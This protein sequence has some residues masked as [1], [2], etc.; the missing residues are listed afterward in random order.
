MELVTKAD[1]LERLRLFSDCPDDDNII[2]KQKIENALMQCPEILYAINERSLEG[3]LFNKDGTI[4]YDGEWDRYFTT[5]YNEGNFRPYLFVPS[6]QDEVKNYVCYQSHFEETP[7]YNGVEKYCLITFTIFV[8]SDHRIDEDTGIPRH[9][10]IGAILKDQ[11]NW[12][13]IFGTQ[14]KVVSDR[15]M[16]TDAKYLCRTIVLQFTMPNSIVQTN[17]YKDNGTK[18]KVTS[19][20]NSLGRM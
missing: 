19:T 17:L 8:H 18:R 14:C 2:V 16:T 10:L 13:N 6:V 12:T 3:E 7:R 1:L 9:D 4:N 11:F 15:E 5:A 20:I